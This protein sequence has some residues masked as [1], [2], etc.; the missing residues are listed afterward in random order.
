MKLEHLRIAAKEWRKAGH[1]SQSWMAAK[2][3]I[4]IAHYCSFETGTRGLSID[5]AEAIEDIISGPIGGVESPE[6]KETGANTIVGIAPEN[7]NQKGWAYLAAQLKTL[8][9]TFADPS[10][11]DAFKR[12]GWMSLIRAHDAAVAHLFHNE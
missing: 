9:D 1:L 7:I 12:E 6:K 4:S 2:L 11:P 5:V 8:S 10:I 3:K